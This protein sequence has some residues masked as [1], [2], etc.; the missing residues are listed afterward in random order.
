MRSVFS[1]VFFCCVFT[2][3]LR[4]Q[5][6]LT[7]EEITPYLFTE[8]LSWMPL[9]K[10]RHLL[11]DEAKQLKPALQL[12]ITGNSIDQ[13]DDQ[14]YRE[15]SAALFNPVNDSAWN[16]FYMI[17]YNMDGKTDVVFTGAVP[18]K[19][20]EI[21]IIWQKAE[22]GYIIEACQEDTKLIRLERAAPFRYCVIS[23]SFN[24]GPL[25][26]YSIRNG[27]QGDNAITVHADLLYPPRLLQPK[28]FVSNAGDTRLRYA[29]VENNAYSEGQSEK[30]GIAIFG[31]ILSKYMQ[32]IRGSVRGSVTDAG[33][34]VWCFVVMNNE[35][36]ALRT[37][38]PFR[39][40]AGWVKASDIK[41]GK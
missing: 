39:V 2:L 23:S 4:G 6:T 31:N 22:R 3:L 14:S 5:A 38:C 29:P 10:F 33:G 8:T 16:N 36:N 9:S 37:H 32:G 40:N 15:Y 13:F 41:T 34:Q 19:R 27:G 11:P 35:Q 20:Y 26:T 17:D 18:G 28:P 24:K 21:T 30:Y 12:A 25:T 1:I 7:P